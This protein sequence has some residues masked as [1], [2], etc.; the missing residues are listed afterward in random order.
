MLLDLDSVLYKSV[1]KCLSFSD[2]REIVENSDDTRAVYESEVLRS[3]LSRVHKK[4]HELTQHVESIHEEL[5]RVELFITTCDNNFRYE[6]EPQYKAGRKKNKYVELLRDFFKSDNVA[7]SDTLEADDLIADRAFELGIDNYIICSIDK[8]LKTIGGYFWS[9]YTINVV[10][11]VG[12]KTK[13]YKQK[14]V[15]YISEQEASRFFYMQ[16]LTGDSVDN[17][18]GLRGVG[19]KRAEK[20]LENSLNDFITVAREFIK[21]DKKDEFWTNYKSLKLGS[22]VKKIKGYVDSELGVNIS[23]RSNKEAYTFGRAIFYELCN[24]Y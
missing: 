22:N 12:F 17:I 13:E 21:R 18:K 1:W 2:I 23:K 14:E 10:D 11:N 20:V 15:D 6:I 19:I 8:D 16:M 7:W 4:V 24:E 9:P 3:S 5:Y